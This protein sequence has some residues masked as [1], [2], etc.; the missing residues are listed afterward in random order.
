MPLPPHPSSPL[1]PLTILGLVDRLCPGAP[2]L[3]SPVCPVAQHGD[4]SGGLG[5]FELD[6]RCGG[7]GPH[8]ADV[9]GRWHLCVGERGKK[10]PKKSG[11]TTQRD[12]SLVTLRSPDGCAKSQTHKTG[13]GGLMK[14]LPRE[15]EH[16]T[17]VGVINLI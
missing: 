1:P 9:R 6:L 14:R 10:N 12:C 2:A 15:N 17:R 11:V 5:L 7:E 13:G 3:N 4:P 8:L 16:C